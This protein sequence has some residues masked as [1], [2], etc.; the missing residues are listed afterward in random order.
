MTALKLNFPSPEPVDTFGTVEVTTTCSPTRGPE[1][2]KT[3]FDPSSQ[4][5]Q[6]RITSKFHRPNQTPT[7]QPKLVGDHQLQHPGC[8][9][10]PVAGR[11][12]AVPTRKRLHL[13]MGW[14]HLH[15]CFKIAGRIVH[16]QN[17]NICSMA[18]SLPSHQKKSASFRISH[19]YALFVTTS[20]SPFPEWPVSFRP[21][22]SIA[23]PSRLQDGFRTLPSSPLPPFLSAVVLVAAPSQSSVF[24][25]HS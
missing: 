25:S 17:E 7:K 21:V 3:V 20:T 1:V 12:S 11:L 13:N 22:D 23:G 6:M 15:N 2:F 9:A 10:T 5:W 18:T 24:D 4:A 16:E 14:L 8:S 19:L